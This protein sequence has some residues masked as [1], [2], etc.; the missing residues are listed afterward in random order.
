MKRSPRFISLAICAFLLLSK[1]GFAL[2][3]LLTP[4]DITSGIQRGNALFIYIVNQGDNC[5]Y[6]GN[7][8]MQCIL[9]DNKLQNCTTHYVQAFSGP[10]KI[11]ARNTNRNATQLFI[12]PKNSNNFYMVQ[13]NRAG[14]ISD[15]AHYTF[16]GSAMGGSIINM[17]YNSFNDKLYITQDQ[18]NHWGNLVVCGF[19]SDTNSISSCSDAGRINTPS[20]TFDNTKSHIFGWGNQ[21]RLSKTDIK[22]P[23]KANINPDG[24]ISSINQGD[25]VSIPAE[26]TPASIATLNNKWWGSFIESLRVNKW[27]DFPPTTNYDLQQFNS[28]LASNIV[29]KTIRNRVFSVFPDDN[30]IEICTSMSDLSC[31]DAFRYL[32]II[33]S[34]TG[35]PVTSLSVTHDSSGTLIFRNVNNSF[36]EHE[37]LTITGIPD[38][39][40]AAFS[41]SCIGKTSFDSPRSS[42]G[43]CSLS[44]N[45]ARLQNEYQGS[46]NYNFSVK[47]NS[48]VSTY[49][50]QFD[51]DNH[52][53]PQ[54]KLELLT[55]DLV[56]QINSL[57]LT[58]ASS[59]TVLI[60]NVSEPMAV[61][62]NINV[63]IPE[64]ISNYFSST[65]ST[66]LVQTPLTLP[67]GESCTLNYI[68][69]TSP[70]SDSQGT[71][72]IQVNSDET[73]I[74][75]TLS[76]DIASGPNL[77]LRAQDDIQDLTR[78]TLSPGSVGDLSVLNTGG[79]A[80]Q[81]VQIRLPSSLSG[82]FSG[83]CITPSTLVAQ[84]GTC[85]LHYEIPLTTLL[86]GTYNMSINSENFEQNFI[87][88]VIS[89]PQIDPN[90]RIGITDDETVSALT[91]RKDLFTYTTGSFTVSNQTDEDIMDF[92]TRISNLGL[93]SSGYIDGS[94]FTTSV[95][96]ARS[97]CNVTYRITDNITPARANIIFGEGTNEIAV[98]PIDIT[99]DPAIEVS[100]NENEID[101]SG[102]SMDASNPSMTFT[103]MNRT[104][105]TITHFNLVASGDA[106]QT[107][108]TN[109]CPINLPAS[110]S[111]EISI[112]LSDQFPAIGRH[113]LNIRGSGLINRNIPFTINKADPD[114]VTID[115]RGGY[116]MYVQS[117]EYHGVGSES[118]SEGTDCYTTTNSGRFTNP[119]S[120]TI[121]SV[122]NRLI[123]FKIIAGKTRS[124]S[125]C[126]GGKI[127]CS[128]ATLNPNCYY[129]DDGSNSINAQNSCAANY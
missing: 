69:P 48:G 4:T 123:Y 85:S 17:M 43:R 115:N 20:F 50:V 37:N 90:S 28:P 59:G 24:H 95:F 81:N 102:I 8:I 25:E 14:R 73:S 72:V 93:H 99:G 118:C 46:F 23:L 126:D 71:H 45:F 105:S 9:V 101:L 70:E 117:T 116:T 13:T 60:Y 97:T 22:Y 55:P 21:A 114:I 52:L 77:V 10:Y 38:E 78:L 76:V 96:E 65:S 89:P 104:L 57:D 108:S 53:P 129:Y 88:I 44:Y 27:T 7:S 120:K 2:P 3:D 61:A 34:E 86:D 82:L 32:T 33:N 35:L 11:I 103:F 15:N 79:T 127:R 87:P 64:Q 31:T 128:R 121:E 1:Q 5:L 66:C 51:I 83:T 16:S 112:H 75:V 80:V 119:H 110:Q 125:S 94:C 47:S 100:A 56:Q 92:S 19:S 84:T 54:P 109:N 111:C 30:K 42:S 113:S 40:R 106:S 67:G 29:L 12:N 49:G 91:S 39:L 41:G 6:G 18:S 36:I 107:I 58:G 122:H 68:I 62:H 26:M 74:P 63:R 124:L 98:L